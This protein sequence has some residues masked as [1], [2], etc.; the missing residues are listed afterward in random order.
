MAD[1]ADHAAPGPGRPADRRAREVD[2]DRRRL[3][4]AVA[5]VPGHLDLEDPLPRGPEA[6]DP[7]AHARR[8]PALLAGDV[9]AAAHDP[10]PA[11]RRVPAAAGHPPGA[12][13]RRAATEDAA[14]GD[15]RPRRREP[16]AARAAHGD[17]RPRPAAPLYSLDD[18]LEE[19]RADADAGRGAR[20]LRR[21]QGR[22]CAAAS[23]T[24]T[25]PSARS[26]APSPSWPA[27]ASP[28]ATCASSAP[29]PTARPR[30]CSRSSPRRCAR[31]TPERRKE[32]VEAL[33]NL[34]A[35]TTHLKH[36]LLIRDLRKIAGLTGAMDLRDAHPRDPGLP[37]AGD[38]LQGH[39]AADGRRRGARRRGHRAGRRGRR[40]RRRLV[41][42]AEARGFLLGP[43]LAREL[44]AGFV[45]AR[46]PGK[47]PHETVRAE[48]VLE[49]GTDT[50]ELHADARRRRRRACS[51]TTTCWPPAAR[52]RRVC[53]LVEQL[54]GEVVGC[55]FLVELAFLGGRG[56]AG[57]PRRPL[58]GRLR[59]RV[60]PTVAR[61]RDVAAPPE[62]RL[63][64]RRRPVPPAALVAAR[65]ARRSGRPAAASPRSSAAPRAG[66]TSAP[67]TASTRS[68]R[69][70]LLRPQE[71]EGTPFERV[72][73][74]AETS[75]AIEPGG[76]G[77]RVADHAGQKLRGLSRL[78]GFMVRR[79]TRKLARR[80]ARRP[81]GAVGTA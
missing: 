42:A 49:Y 9:A 69:A 56:A 80:G 41:I 8:L 78:G 71:L 65:R 14:A 31:A 29:R 40:R 64:A 5:G 74:E 68:A 55:V 39:H 76:G 58:A 77:T 72:L 2:D 45:L 53:A 33:E 34:A 46:K 10:A 7:A 1:D 75:I 73:R 47:L 60:M 62:R 13:H 48:Y 35:V 44:G 38:R 3:Q 12:G 28:G 6:A 22:A 67:T 37:E 32:A 81:G 27:T 36:L 70:E 66:A 54:G 21:H 52:P 26:S 50:L 30:C 16:R 63:A 43:A 19:T 4:G 11:A 25:R 61:A 51:S 79:A 23:S 57:G 18:V 24:T 59:D 20:G 15:G 17:Q